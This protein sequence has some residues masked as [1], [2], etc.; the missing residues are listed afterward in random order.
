MFLVRSAATK[1]A[2]YHELIRRPDVSRLLLA[3]A[4]ARLAERMLTLVL[5]LYAL[6]R[7]HSAPLAGWVGFAAMAPGLLVSPLAGALLDRLGSA[8]AIAVD[9]ACSAGCVL[10]LSLLAVADADSASSLVILVAVYSLTS[11]LSSAGVRALL[12]TLVPPAAFDR[13]NALDT[14]IHAVIEVV[15]PAL[16]GALFGLAGAAITLLLIAGLYGAACV[17]L[18]R[19]PLNPPGAPRIRGGGLLTDAAA[20]VM[21]VLRHRSLRALAVAY[22]T[23]QVSW[24][25]LLVAAPVFVV[26]VMGGGTNSGLIVGALWAV[27]GIAGGVGALV[28]GHLGALGR[29]RGVIALGIMATALAIYPVSASLGLFGL[30]VGLALVGFL[31]GPIDVGVLTLRQRRTDPAWLGRV[32]AVSMSLNLSGLPI[33]SALGGVL[34]DCSLSW[35]FG[36]AAFAC[37]LAAVATWIL[38]PA[39]P[40]R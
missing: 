14:S 16:A 37:V 17:S 35:T 8:P 29:E 5:V 25:I 20:G 9:M 26:H 23:Y 33:G 15:G 21:Y 39:R 1:R 13:A 38:V 4:L 24:G 12:P 30:G 3:A 28:A 19:A 22:A 10:L 32:M 2:S 40:D 7:F 18:L 36:A 6:D 11:P 27:S 31:A 34:S